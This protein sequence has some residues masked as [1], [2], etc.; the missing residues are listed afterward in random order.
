MALQDTLMHMHLHLCIGM[1]VIPYQHLL[2]LPAA[3][4]LRLM[5]GYATPGF[6]GCNVRTVFLICF[7]SSLFVLAYI[8]IAYKRDNL[9]IVKV[10]SC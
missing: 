5:Y 1:H 6:E 7:S 9:K 2:P 10:S 4:A 3:K 8:D